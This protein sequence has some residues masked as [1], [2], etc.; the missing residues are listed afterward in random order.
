MPARDPFTSDDEQRLLAALPQL[1]LRDQALILV[2]LDTGF[3]A[4]ELG[5]MEIRHVVDEH[6]HVR[7][8]LTLERRHLKH[9]RGAYR[10]KVRSRV[11]PLS[12]RARAVL[13]QYLAARSARGVPAPSDALFPARGTRGRQGISIWQVN[14]IVKDAASRAGC[15]PDANIGSHSLRKSFAAR[16]YARS[17]HDINLTRAALG[18]SSILT[19]QRYLATPQGDALEA[20]IRSLAETAA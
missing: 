4:R 6:G 12:A 19:T 15:S 13:E 8:R 7:Q 10:D 9:G 20:V 14:R 17:G 16:I 2:G 11:V 5:A 3:R 18:H 1:P